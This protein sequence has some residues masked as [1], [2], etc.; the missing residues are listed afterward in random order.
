MTPLER[1]KYDRQAARVRR[2]HT[3][4]YIEPYSIGSHTHNV[5]TL[6]ALAWHDQYGELPRAELLLAAQ[7]HDKGEL[8]TGD[9]PSPIKDLLDGRLDEVDARIERELFG[10]L[11]LTDTETEFLMAADRFELWLW[12]W[13]ELELGNNG[14]QDWRQGYEMY[15]VDHPLPAPFSIWLKEIKESRGLGQ[16]TAKQVMQIGG[17][18]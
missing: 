3:K 6:V 11:D 17:L 7:A 2:C 5:V 18:G 8:V 1:L 9:F 12:C 4:P 15:W 14:V 10:R 16:F 13:D